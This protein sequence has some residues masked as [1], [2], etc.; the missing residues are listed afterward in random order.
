[1][2]D[3]DKM[4]HLDLHVPTI[5]GVYVYVCCQFTSSRWQR[6]MFLSKT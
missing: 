6:N 1:M 2:N 3:L 5:Q 4:A